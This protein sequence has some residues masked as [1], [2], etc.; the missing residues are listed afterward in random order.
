MTHIVSIAKV[1]EEA[2]MTSDTASGVARLSTFVSWRPPLP[3]ILKLNTGASLEGGSGHAFGGGLIRDTTGSWRCGFVANIGVCS[4]LTAEIWCLLHGLQLAKNM[5]I[6]KLEVESDSF[7]GVS[8]IV[9]NFE[10]TINCRSIVRKV[11]SLLHEFD[12]VVL[13]HVHR[14]GNFAADFLSHYAFNFYKGV[15]V[16]ESP[17]LGFSIWLMYDRLGVCYVR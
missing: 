4:I 15:H 6:R 13:R 5:G 7:T 12:L 14:E 9:G 10:V 17:S 16:L 8:M 3:D 2:K 1:V 11:Q